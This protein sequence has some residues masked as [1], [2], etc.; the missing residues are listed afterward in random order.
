MCAFAHFAQSETFWM[1]RSPCLQM[2]TGLL[3]GCYGDLRTLHLYSLPY[4][5]DSLLDRGHVA[6]SKVTPLDFNHS[7][8]LGETI[9]FLDGASGSAESQT[10]TLATD[11]EKV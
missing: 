9:Y 4:T 11:I 7:S 2:N 3:G 5:T 8:V 6:L 1:A 10:F